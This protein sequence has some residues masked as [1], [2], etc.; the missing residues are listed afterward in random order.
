MGALTQGSPA[1]ITP[2]CVCTRIRPSGRKCHLPPQQPLVLCTGSTCISA[3]TA[4]LLLLLTIYTSPQPAAQSE[5]Q[6]DSALCCAF[7]GLQVME[8]HQGL[9]GFCSRRPLSSPS[10]TIQHTNRET[11]APPCG[12]SSATPDS[13]TAGGGGGQRARPDPS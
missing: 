1:T 8:L 7:P 12:P 2:L 10:T 13:D 4:M 11:A 9:G 3:N 5:C 6:F